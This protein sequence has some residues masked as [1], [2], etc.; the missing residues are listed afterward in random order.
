MGASWAD[1][2]ILLGVLAQA[3]GIWWLALHYTR[4]KDDQAPLRKN[5]QRKRPGRKGK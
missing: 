3:L 4:D 1:A 5:R 2:A